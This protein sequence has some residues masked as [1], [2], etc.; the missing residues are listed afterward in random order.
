MTDRTPCAV[1]FCRRSR[2][3][4]KGETRPAEEWICGDHWTLVSKH[5][6][7]RF[8]KFSRLYRRRFG[9]VAF[10][11]FP[12]GSPKRIEA[13]KITRLWRESWERCKR[14]AV[15]RAMGIAA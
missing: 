6:R 3:I 12:A 7:R 8:A 10:W 5:L 1:P 4:R 9:D 14:Q 2:G 13:V 15:E 11:T